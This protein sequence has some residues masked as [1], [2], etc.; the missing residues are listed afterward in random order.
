M[1]EFTKLEPKLCDYVNSLTCL[2][3][4]R[5]ISSH[6]FTDRLTKLLAILCTALDSDFNFANTKT[7][8]LAEFLQK[9]AV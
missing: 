9:S 6:G 7:S 8:E 3:V 1:K 2:H 4:I 5:K